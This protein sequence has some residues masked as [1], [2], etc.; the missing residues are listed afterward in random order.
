MAILTASARTAL[1]I[2][3]H[4]RLF[5]DDAFLIFAC[6]ALTTLFATVLYYTSTTSLAEDIVNGQLQEGSTALP[7]SVNLDAVISR[8]RKAQ[9]LRGSLAWLTIFA[10]KF[11]FLSF[12]YPLT[13]RLPRLFLYWRVVVAVNVLAFVYC[14]ACGFLGCLDSS[15]KSCEQ[16]YQF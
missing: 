16:L 1:R 7:P 10:V 13:D 8:F 12:F 6:L 2:K 4:R 5:V 3:L 11:A 15:N 14:I 9:L